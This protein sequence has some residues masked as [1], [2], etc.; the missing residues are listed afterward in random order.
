M[1]ITAMIGLT[2]R[3][4]KLFQ[5]EAFQILSTLLSFALLIGGL[6]YWV[7]SNYETIENVSLNR[8]TRYVLVAGVVLFVLSPALLA[9]LMIVGWVIAIVRKLFGEGNQGVTLLADRTPYRFFVHPESGRFKIVSA[10]RGKRFDPADLSISEKEFAQAPVQLNST[11]DDDLVFI[12]G[13]TSQGSL[14][15]QRKR[16]R[17]YILSA[18]RRTN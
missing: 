18:N 15:T 17:F 3:Q 9:A 14:I 11:M 1:F 4:T 6:L 5:D 7:K 2:H 8:G 16:S 13:A 12:D 10:G